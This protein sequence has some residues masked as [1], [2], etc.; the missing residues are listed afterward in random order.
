MNFWMLMATATGA[1][2]IPCAWTCLR[3]SPERRLVGLEMT[4]LVITIVMVLVTVGEGRLPFMDIPLALAVLAFGAG[5]V[6]A[7]FLEK[8]L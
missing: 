7:R 5:L 8:H 3:G 1:S 6:F 4:A 2:L